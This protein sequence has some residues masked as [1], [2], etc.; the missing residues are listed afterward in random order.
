V[1]G[2]ADDSAAG[3][4][5]RPQAEIHA[6]DET[7][8]GLRRGDDDGVPGRLGDRRHMRDD[9]TRPTRDEH[10]VRLHA[11]P[12]DEDDDDDEDGTGGRS[13]DDDSPERNARHNRTASGQSRLKLAAN[14]GWQSTK[15][16]AAL[17]AM[18]RA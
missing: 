5:R 6:R 1:I 7:Q 9:T 15:R 8:H 14:S 12:P 10:R 11:A 16:D 13:Y 3:T 18:A 2:N 17:S 4:G